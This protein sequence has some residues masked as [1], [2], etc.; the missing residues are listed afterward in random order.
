VGAIKEK[1]RKSGILNKILATFQPYLSSWTRIQKSGK[2]LFSINK[3]SL[4]AKPQ[5]SSFESEGEDRG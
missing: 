1:G 2:Q 5:P 4:Y 3:R